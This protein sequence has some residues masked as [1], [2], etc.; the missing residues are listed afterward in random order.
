MNAQAVLGGSAPRTFD[1]R[2]GFWLWQE[3]L[4]APAAWPFI[5]W[6]DLT[7]SRVSSLALLLAVSVALRWV[8]LILVNHGKEV[9]VRRGFKMRT[10]GSGDRAESG[11]FPDLYLR[12]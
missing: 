5:T 7:V 8:P 9:D 10:F 1:F 6:S 12:R 4:S 2:Q 3:E 11:C